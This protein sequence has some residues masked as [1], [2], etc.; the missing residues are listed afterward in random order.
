MSKLTIGLV[1]E[2]QLPPKKV[3]IEEASRTNNDGIQFT[4]SNAVSIGLVLTLR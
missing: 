3:G 4:D 1:L 2:L